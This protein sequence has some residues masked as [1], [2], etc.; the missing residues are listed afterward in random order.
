MAY[1]D[2]RFTN[3]IFSYFLIQQLSGKVSFTLFNSFL[4]AQQYIFGYVY[5]IKPSNKN[6][7]YSCKSHV[8]YFLH[9]KS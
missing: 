1:H 5:E 3:F 9:H 8:A 7:T 6:K 2:G 4:C